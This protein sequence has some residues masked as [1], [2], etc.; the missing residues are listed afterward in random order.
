[1]KTDKII[2]FVFVE[3][4]EKPQKCPVSL[5]QSARTIDKPH[6]VEVSGRGRNF[7]RTVHPAERKKGNISHWNSRNRTWAVFSSRERLNVTFKIPQDTG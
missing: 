1:M 2:P 7:P 4:P 3:W 5:V 6:Q